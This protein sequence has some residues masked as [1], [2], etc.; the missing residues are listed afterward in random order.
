M[1]Y[2]DRYIVLLGNLHA[3]II[4]SKWPIVGIN[5]RSVLF[6]SDIWIRENVRYS[7]GTDIWDWE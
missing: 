4:P 1:Q 2:L 6:K 7:L 3:E 5:K